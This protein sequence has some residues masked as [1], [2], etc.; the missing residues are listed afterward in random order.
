MRYKVGD[1][2]R[3]KSNL[4]GEEFNYVTDNMKTFCGKLGRIIKVNEPYNTD[5]D[6]IGYFLSFDKDNSWIEDYEWGINAFEYRLGNYEDN[7]IENHRCKY[8]IGYKTNKDGKTKRFNG[9]IENFAPCN[10]S[11]FVDENGKTLVL[12]WELIEYI[13]PIDD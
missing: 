1:Y 10:K 9:F 13:I 6:V 4:D 2:V 7:N 12:P 8:V 5:D 11:V 3:I